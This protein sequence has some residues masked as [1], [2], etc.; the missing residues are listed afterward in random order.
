MKKEAT[1]LV[2]LICLACIVRSESSS[3]D[4]LLDLEDVDSLNQDSLIA[5]GSSANDE[6]LPDELELPAET[7]AALDEKSPQLENENLQQSGTVEP[8]FSK[9]AQTIATGL[10]G[11]LFIAAV[12]M[13]FLR[14]SRR[15]KEAEAEESKYDMPVQQPS[16]AQPHDAVVTEQQVSAPVEQSQATVTQQNEVLSAMS[17]YIR[18]SLQKGYAFEQIKAVLNKQGYSDDTINQAYSMAK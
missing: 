7:N 2:L 11:A 5:E 6:Q 12:V 10:L 16:V 14:K 17:N 15:K 18:D 1:F 8:Q 9:S 4:M 13:Y 3:P